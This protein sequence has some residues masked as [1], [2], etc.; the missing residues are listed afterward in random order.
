MDYDFDK[1]LIYMIKEGS[2]TDLEHMMKKYEPLIK[3]LASKYIRTYPYMNVEYEDLLQEGKI[4]LIKIMF[5]YDTNNAVSFSS[6]FYNCLIKRMNSILRSSRAQKNMITSNLYSID[7]D[8]NFLQI[9]DSTNLFSNIMYSE[10]CEKIIKFKH[11]LSFT[12]S[13]I[14]E[15][16]SNGFSYS[17]IS[18]IV[19]IDIK[20]VDNRLVKIKQKF[21]K[22]ISCFDK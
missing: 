18:K 19:E 14:F 3:R 10:L 6:F 20:S 2:E 12:N 11:E 9:A 5:H 8:E 22:F 1:E 16:K 4:I 17:D 13:I 7:D 21:S 15:L